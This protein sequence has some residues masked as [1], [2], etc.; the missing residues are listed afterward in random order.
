M[1]KRIEFIDAMRGFTMILVVMAHVISFGY[2]GI[3]GFSWGR[4][5][6]LF[7]MPLFFFISGFI[8]FKASREWSSGVTWDFIKKKFKIQIIP[9]IVF[10][11]I[12]LYL[13][14]LDFL[15]AVDDKYKAGYWFT[16]ILFVYFLIY[17]YSSMVM[18]KCLHIGGGKSDCVLFVIG[19]F[20]MFLDTKYVTRAMA[21]HHVV[22]VF[23]VQQWKFFVFFVI[24]VLVRRYFDKV[25]KILDD[26]YFMPSVIVTF[27]ASVLFFYDV[28]CNIWWMKLEFLGWGLLGLIIV[29]SFFKKY[30]AS[31][32]ND[33]VQGRVLQYIG[34][35]TLD[36]YLLH[37]ILLPRNLQMF[38]HFF[39]ENHNPT[40]ELFISLLLS[41]IVIAICLL[42]SNIIRLSP[43]LA[44]WLFGVKRLN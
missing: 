14:N 15:D 38:G 4:F 42:T 32:R 13:F 10:L 16:P 26:S 6:T 12:Y 1:T 21:E 20:F 39:S 40:L 24:G 22:N 31:F 2:S 41:L 17:S 3:E 5:F 29:F 44:H 30:E 35:R 36:I 34:K 7:R 11:S 9:T 33:T 8:M 37:Y 25:V 43:I 27:I 18:N 23:S 19:L 28:E